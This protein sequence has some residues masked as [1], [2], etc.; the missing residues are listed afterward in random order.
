MVI[1][2]TWFGNARVEPLWVQY[3]RPRA[4]GEGR[5]IAGRHKCGKFTP[6]TPRLVRQNQRGTEAQVIRFVWSHTLEL[7]LRPD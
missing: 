4:G 6:L 5:A 2:M 1:A 7:V 3:N